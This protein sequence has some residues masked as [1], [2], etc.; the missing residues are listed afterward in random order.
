MQRQRLSRWQKCVENAARRVG[1]TEHLACDVTRS[2]TADESRSDGHWGVRYA[3]VYWYVDLQ[4][5]LT[6][7]THVGP[8]AESSCA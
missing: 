4:A 7:S 8:T 1:G 5:S 6:L 2:V 3:A